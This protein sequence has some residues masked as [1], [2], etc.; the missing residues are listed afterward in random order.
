MATLHDDADMAAQLERTLTGAYCGSADL[1]EA[2]TTSARVAPGDYGQWYEEWAHTA[3]VALGAAGAAAAGGHGLMAARGYLRS[4]EYWRQAYFFLRHDVA[5]QRVRTGYERQRDAFRKAAPFLPFGVEPAPIPFDGAAMPG[6]AYR[7]APGG[8]RPT[9]LVTGGFDGTAEELYKYGVTAALEAGW[10]AVAWDGPGQGGMLVEHGVAM[11]PDF[12]AV[13]TAVVDWTLEQRDFADPRRLMLVGRS[14]GCYLAPCG[15]S[16][17]PRIAALAT[18]V[19][20]GEGD[21]ASQSHTL[22]DALTCPKQYREFAAAE[23][24]GGHCEG[25]GQMLWQ[26]ASFA[27]LSETLATGQAGNSGA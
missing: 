3:E 12:E 4:A 9:V 11:R 17:E 27:W 24:A 5:D 13:L 25:M 7:V 16:G 23:G 1:G 6:Y 18:L 2:I 10:N 22:F 8:Q 21:F 14:L 20:E 26:Q 19:T 15:A